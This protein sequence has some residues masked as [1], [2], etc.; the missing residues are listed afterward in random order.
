MAKA[1]R[2][3][4]GA[5]YLQKWLV[6]GVLIG[7]MA[8]TGAI[9][10][11]E[12]LLGA[13]HL[14]LG[15]LAGYHVPTPI[16][17]GGRAASGSFSR[18]W[19]L[20]LVVGL[21][22]LLGALLAFR[23]APDAE[24]HG[25]DAAISAVHH[26]PR[27][28]RF[29][30]VIVKIVA[31]ALTIGSGGSG[32]R[33]GP[34]GQISAGFAS[35][36]ARE[37]DLSPADGRTAVA[38]GIGS[39]IGAIF[40]APL[41]G[42]VLATEI[43]YR[44]DFDVEALLPCFIASIVGYVIF[45][46]ATGFTP[47]FGF[48][49]SYHFGDPSQLLWFALIGVLG[50]ITGLLYAKGFYGI[51]ALFTR[52]ALPRWVKPAIG[53]VLVGSIALAIPE[54]LGTGY[55]WIQ[56]SLGHQ[57]LSLPLWVVLILPFARIVATGL[58]IGSGGS[59]GI[60]GPG[61]VIGAFVGAGVWRL[62]EPIVPSMGHS[63]TPYVIVGMMCCFGSI[64]RAPLAVMLMVAEMTGSLSILAPAM[65]AVGLAWFIVRRDDDSIY[66]SQLQSRAASPAQRLLVGM[67]L[68]GNVAVN[69]AMAPPRLVLKGGTPAHLARRQ[70]ER[71]GVPG[72]PVVD[73]QG[74][75]EGALSLKDL[76]RLGEGADAHTIDAVVDPSAPT[77]AESSHL[78]VALDALT[79]ASQQW[80][81]VLDNDRAV[82]G[83]IAMSDVVRGYRLGLLASLHQLDGTD[84][85]A[86]TH[87]IEI[88]TRSSLVN[89]PLRH[90]RL[91]A[92]VI[93]TSIQRGR[94]LLVPDGDTVLQAGDRL[95]VIG[96]PKDVD[97]LKAAASHASQRRSTEGDH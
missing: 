90:A 47:L 15:V 79:S 20:P 32:G 12:A 11:Y 54:V 73:D 66:R 83:T 1:S 38:T 82:V 2:W 8:G 74:R 67:P 22:A 97:G 59:G 51:A 24:G 81:P 49:A 50:G 85:A 95:A 14:L 87:D 88:T 78:D 41:G 93:V 46:A 31:S 55:G 48:N 72:V 57:L 63:P 30:T 36:L 58:S 25:T 5:S 44:D 23:F 29:R 53:G 40:G 52:I 65:V 4:A 89:A 76:D 19:A 26:N 10:F 75:F 43:L 71:A 16:G 39:G 94:E 61:M 37:L 28:I 17:E 80:I 9:V 45:G 96:A 69:Q 27:G 6:L 21:G 33:E 77:V 84:H 42:A 18:P 35:L 7:A 60:F 56:Q 91:P 86:G 64:S 3:L 34:T 13:T 92:G 68:L 70:V 62:F